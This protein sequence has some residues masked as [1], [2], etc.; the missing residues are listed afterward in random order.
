M[1]ADWEKDLEER[2]S[3]IREASL[4][5]S[6][7]VLEGMSEPRVR[8][9]DREVLQFA[10]NDYLGLAAHPLLREAAARAA[11]DHGAGAGASRLISGTLRVHA[12]LEDRLAAFKGAPAALAFS[13][14]YATAVGVLPAILDKQDIAIVDKRIHACLVDGV[15]LS[16]AVLRVFAHNDLDQLERRLKWADGQRRDASGRIQHRVLILTES[17][18]SMDGDLAPLLNIVELKEKYGAW[19]MVDEAHATG[20]Y[21]E[22]LGGLI[23]EFD[24]RD[25]VEIQ[26]GT[27]GKAL[28]ASGGYVTGSRTFIDY[29]VQRSRSLVFSTAPSPAACAAAQAGLELLGGEEGQERRFRLWAVVDQARRLLLESGWTPEAVRSPIIPLPVGGEKEAMDLAAFLWDRCL[30]VPAIRYPTVER[31]KARLRCSLTASH[32]LAML[33]LL[34]AGLKEARQVA[35]KEACS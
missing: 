27:L 3:E 15:R 31:G 16:G 25:R 6:I 9:G 28:G 19:L 2:L 4:L 8:V 21:G 13:N 5:R 34:A 11:R 18:F 17:V 26:M 14:G 7:R 1:N 10:S 23:E 29:L 35:P 32:T 20:L 30:W 22:R 12:D 24:L 33:Q